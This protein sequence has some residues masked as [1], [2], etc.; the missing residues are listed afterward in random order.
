MNETI[1]ERT[2]RRRWLNLAEMV[3]LASV[4]IAAL[5]LYLTWSERRDAAADKA[6]TTVAGARLDLSATPADAGRILRLSDAKHE[7]TDLKLQYPAAL[8]VPV[9]R[10]PGEPVVEAKAIADE[11]LHQTDGG[12]D[13]RSGRV[14]VLITASYLD[15]DVSRTAS[16]VYDVS[17]ETHGRRLRGRALELTGLHLR[18]RG[19]GQAA[20]EQ[21]WARE[22]P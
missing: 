22:K 1:E 2:R 12:P 5:G 16:G 17:W 3:A 6:A 13:D 15:G 8:G 21:A 10:P 20:L 7:L 9:Q 18:Q 19:G 14:P 11:L 4:V